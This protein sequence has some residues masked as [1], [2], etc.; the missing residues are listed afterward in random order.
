VDRSPRINAGLLE[1]RRTQ[2]V[3]ESCSS[4]P[5]PSASSAVHLPHSKPSVRNSP[6]RPRSV[7]RTARVPSTRVIQERSSITDAI[8][9]PAPPARC[10]VAVAG[11]IPARRANSPAGSASPPSSAPSSAARVGSPIMPATR[12][13]SPSGVGRVRMPRVVTGRRF[14]IAP[15]IDQ[16]PSRSPRVTCPSSST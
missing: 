1:P 12:A 13:S 15:T 6:S 8:A 3:A 9:A 7:S 5:R 10:D 4:S 11:A 16:V 2:R 14:G